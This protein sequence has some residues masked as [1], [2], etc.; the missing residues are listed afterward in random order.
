MF[1]AWLLNFQLRKTE[2]K[3]A[4]VLAI[5]SICA[6]L[7]V[8]LWVSLAP[9]NISKTPAVSTQQ[10]TM[11]YTQP[12]PDFFQT[13]DQTKNH[14]LQSTHQKTAPTKPERYLAS[15][16]PRQPE[17]KHVT[18]L[19]IGKGTYY[20]QVGAFNQAKLAQKLFEKVKHQYK[21]AKIKFKVDKYAVWVGP[22]LSRSD[23]S[24]LKKH[25]QQKNNLKGFIVRDK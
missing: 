12:Q 18:Q 10:T 16:A 14:T 7:L 1:K 22:V 2:L 17:K 4:S 15:E 5:S 23:A 13:Q 8:V 19:N 6:A 20:V 9:S 25:L 3:V 21:H 11:V 24:I